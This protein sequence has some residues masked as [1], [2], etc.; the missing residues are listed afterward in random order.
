M[1]LLKSILAGVVAVIAVVVLSAGV[2]I[3]WGWWMANGVAQVGSVGA[4]AYDVNTPWIM[5]P[6][7]LIVGV[8]FFAGFYWEYRRA[9]RTNPVPR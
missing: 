8:V 4:V 9:R 1:V 7:P 5:I 6:L 3:A 2:F